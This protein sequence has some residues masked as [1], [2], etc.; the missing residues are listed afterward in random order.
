MRNLEKAMTAAMDSGELTCVPAVSGE[1]GVIPVDACWWMLNH[2]PEQFAQPPLNVVELVWREMHRERHPR[3]CLC[4]LC[5]RCRWLLR[6][7]GQETAV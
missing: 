2:A 1:R 7:A 6:W 4:R 3:F 5:Q